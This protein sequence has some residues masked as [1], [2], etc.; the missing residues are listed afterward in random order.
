MLMLL[1]AAAL[2]AAPGP[3]YPRAPAPAAVL[4]G[5]VTDTAGT[6]LADVRV[7][8]LE[9]GRGTT[10]DAAGK[11]A[12]P[13]LPSGTYG[14]AFSRIGYA[15]VV[16]RVT[17]G[18]GDVALTMAMRPSAVELPEVQVTATS[19]VTTALASP[20]PTSI[21]DH[22]HLR[23]AQAPSLGETIN[24]L[25]GVHTI[26]EGPAIGKPVIRGLSSNRVLVL[27]NGQRIETQG[28]GDEHSPNI[29]TADAE[30]IEVI[31]GPA[32]VLY[33][34][35]ALGGVVNVVK[36]DLPDALGHASFVRGA[37]SRRTAR[38]TSSPTAPPDSRAP[39]A[40]WGSARRSRAAP[41]TT[42]VP[43]SAM[44]SIPATA[45]WPATGRSA[46][47]GAGARSGPT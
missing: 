45:P 28:W 16:R 46:T 41:A 32:S 9:V 42:S 17:V 30:R 8:L 6:P 38:T 39:R 27:D 14:V 35:D 7:H 20:Q 1:L 23:V 19:G 21:L 2:A 31:Q 3:S 22:A 40:G 43:R 4:T 15:P 10:T 12:L 26:N 13:E 33:G 29:E 5:T 18:A 37:L 34:S 36:R 24:G 44:S 25:A 11:F 47:V